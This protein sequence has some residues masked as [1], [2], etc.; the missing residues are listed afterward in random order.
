MGQ[1]EPRL[2]PPLARP[3]PTLTPFDYCLTGIEPRRESAPRLILRQD[4]SI[5]GLRTME[6]K[7]TN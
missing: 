7:P 5:K 1:G 3:N 4:K 2:P 6:H